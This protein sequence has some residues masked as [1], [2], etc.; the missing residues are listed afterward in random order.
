MTIRAARAS[1]A[2]TKSDAL[3]EMH[4]RKPFLVAKQCLGIARLQPEDQSDA[5][6]PI[7]SALHQYEHVVRQQRQQCSKYCAI[8][9][10]C[11]SKCSEA[12][13]PPPQ[14]FMP[15]ID[16]K[17]NKTQCVNAPNRGKAPSRVSNHQTRHPSAPAGTASVDVDHGAVVS[18]TMRPIVLTDHDDICY[19]QVVHDIVRLRRVT[20]AVW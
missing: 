1:C 3:S 20:S 13:T 17:H 7:V 14:T 2:N 10:C 15:H 12:Q 11:L 9:F 8:F 4:H 16:G 18:P 19:E 5:G 6:A